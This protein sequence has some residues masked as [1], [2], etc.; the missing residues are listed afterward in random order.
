MYQWKGCGVQRC[1]NQYNNAGCLLY[2]DF[3]GVF[4]CGIDCN[5]TSTCKQNMVTQN[6]LYLPLEVRWFGG[7][8]FGVTCAVSIPAGAFICE[9]FGQVMTDLEAEF[10]RKGKDK[11][12][13]SLHHF[14]QLFQIPPQDKLGEEDV[15]K[16]PPMSKE[17]ME[18][19][20]QPHLVIDALFHGN[21]GRFINHSCDPNVTTQVVLKQN[22][23]FLHYSLCFFASKDISAGTELCYDYFWSPMQDST[24]CDDQVYCRCGAAQCKGRL[25]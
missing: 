2:T 18:K 4:E 8:G 21:V 24:G 1:G 7:K 17:H 15:A 20:D 14:L 13:Y 16:L 9:Y 19:Q 12:L 3:K 10:Q 6:G 11:Y 25:L 23:S 5:N 22:S